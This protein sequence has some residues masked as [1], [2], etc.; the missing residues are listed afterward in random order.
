[1]L[2][3]SQ[4]SPIGSVDETSNSY[5]MLSKISKPLVKEQLEM[6]QREELM[7][8]IEHMADQK[9][10]DLSERNYT[11]QNQKSEPLSRLIPSALQD[12]SIQRAIS[13]LSTVSHGSQRRR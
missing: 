8:H 5:S 2:L 11:K 4:I 3:R 7:H 10:K 6:I 1:M 13:K 12:K 9:I